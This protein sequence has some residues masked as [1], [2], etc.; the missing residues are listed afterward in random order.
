M[1]RVHY[2]AALL[3]LP[4]FHCIG[5]RIGL[6]NRSIVDYFHSHEIHY[7]FFFFLVGFICLFILYLENKYLW[8]KVFGEIQN[9]T[10]YWIVS[11]GMAS[12]IISTWDAN[13]LIFDCI[14]LCY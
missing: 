2:L 4:I 7:Y 9:S 3:S 12:G 11:P 10:N 13:T 1:R 8:N 14:I 5:K 6:S